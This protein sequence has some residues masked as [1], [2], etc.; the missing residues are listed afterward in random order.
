MTLDVSYMLCDAGRATT[1]EAFGI[2]AACCW[3]NICLLLASSCWHNMSRVMITIMHA[4]A[5]LQMV[6][7]AS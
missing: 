4:C 5:I 2:I 3:H 7:H 6:W 1:V